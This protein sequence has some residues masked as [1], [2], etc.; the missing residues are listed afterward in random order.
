MKKSQVR[1]F[2]DIFNLGDPGRILKEIW[3]ILDTIVVERNNIAHGKATPEEVGRSY[4]REDVRKLVDSWQARWLEFIAYVEV[5]A[6]GRDFYR[7]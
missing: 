4:S 1:L 3:V 2:C 7:K 5:E 6:A